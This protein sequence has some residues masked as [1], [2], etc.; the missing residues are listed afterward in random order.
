MQL[1]EIKALTA[2]GYERTAHVFL[3]DLDK[4][5]WCHFIQHDE[6][7]EAGQESVKL[8]TGDRVE[9]SFSIQLVNGYTLQGDAEA[10]GFKQP[11]E[12]SSHI[13]AV[14][15]VREIIDEYS[16]LCDIGLLGEEVTV[17]FE[18]SVTVEPGAII[19][20]RGSLEFDPEPAS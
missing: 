11:I 13:V 16:C 10:P 1:V 20:I 4:S 17:E 15:E 5:V 18:D 9:G 12:E 3:I 6:Y 2:D 7:L 8:K 14:C 19:T